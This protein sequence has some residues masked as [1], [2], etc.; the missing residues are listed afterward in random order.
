MMN[1]TW[2]SGSLML[3]AVGFRPPQ[4]PSRATGELFSPND[5]NGEFATLKGDFRGTVAN[6]RNWSLAGAHFYGMV[7]T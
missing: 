6:T 7:T 5:C 4:D 3:V 2:T 1:N